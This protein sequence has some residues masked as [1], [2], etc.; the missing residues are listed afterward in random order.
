VS[1]NEPP[2][3]EPQPNS[4]Q[5]VPEREHSFEIVV[6]VPAGEDMQ[7]AQQLPQNNNQDHQEEENNEE[8]EEGGNKAQGE[9]DE[10]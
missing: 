4:P 2:P 8:E 5:Y 6:T 7:D 3:L 10:V 1:W 9:E